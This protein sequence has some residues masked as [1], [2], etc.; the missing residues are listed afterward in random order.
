M[1]A[2]FFL[3]SADSETEEKNGDGNKNRGGH[4]MPQMEDESTVDEEIGKKMDVF[5]EIFHRIIGNH[6]RFPN[7]RMS[8]TA[9]DSFDLTKY[10]STKEVEIEP[11]AFKSVFTEFIAEM[12]EKMDKLEEALPG[13]VAVLDHFK[14]QFKS[15]P[16]GVFKP[17][18]KEEDFESAARRAGKAIRDLEE[19]GYVKTYEALPP[20]KTG[21][22]VYLD[23]KTGPESYI[24]LFECVDGSYRGSESTPE[25]ERRIIAYV[26]V[27]TS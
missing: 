1:T 15:A 12:R 17:R 19:R 25:S 2:H 8:T 6:R 16:R 3:S 20:V 27:I 26:K 18:I 14:T 24:F 9:R 10:V 4:K 7:F 22:Y 23:A 21:E 11:A 5:I 13:A